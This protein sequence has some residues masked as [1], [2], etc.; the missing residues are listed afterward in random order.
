M[1]RKVLPRAEL[2]RLVASPEGRV[3]VDPRGSLP[4]RGVWI[5][6]TAEHLRQLARLAPRIQRDLEAEVDAEAL[7]A[8]VRAL[9]ARWGRERLGLAAKAGALVYG[10]DALLQ[11]I[12]GGRVVGVLIAADAAQRTEASVRQAAEAAGVEIVRLRTTTE[13]TGAAIGRAL[14]A[15]LGVARSSLTHTLMSVLRRSSDLG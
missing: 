1:S 6:P 5:E 2:L 9:Y 10:H 11:A 8:E 15:V 14:A 4:G 3:V 7:V 13:E 12:S